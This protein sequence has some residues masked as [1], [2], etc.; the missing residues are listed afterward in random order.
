VQ[1][2]AGRPLVA[3]SP[4]GCPLRGPTPKALSQRVVSSGKRVP[5]GISEMT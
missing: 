5:C 4:T 3:I 2:S 1:A